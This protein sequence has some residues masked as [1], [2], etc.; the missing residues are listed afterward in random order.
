MDLSDYRPTATQ[1]GFLRSRER[2]AGFFSGYGGGKTRAGA[3]KALRLALANPGCTGLIAAPTWDMNT[4]LTQRAFFAACPK[5]LI[6]R[7]HKTE[8]WV[9]LV[10]GARIYFGSTDK[11]GSL[12]GTNLA[13]FW[14][15]EARLTSSEAWRVIVG[16]LRD[17]GARRLQGFVTTTPAM[18]W[19]NDEFGTGRPEREA[20]H[21]STLENAHN[22]A[23]GFIENLRRTYSPRLAKALI[24]GLFAVI[25]GQVYEEFDES[26]HVIDW[27]FNPRLPLWLSWDFGIRASSILFAQVTGDFPT[28]LASGRTIPPRSVVIFDELQLEQKPTVHQIPEVKRKL[29]ALR[30][31][32]ARIVCDPAGKQ[33]DQASG[34]PSVSLLRDAFGHIVRWEEEFAQRHIPNRI[35]RVQ[36]ALHPVEGEPT[37]YVARSLLSHPSGS[38]EARRG[39]VRSLRGSVYPEREGRR[40]S[41]L[42]KEDEFE[43]ARDTLEYLVVRAQNETRRPGRATGGTS[44][45]WGG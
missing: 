30:A 12:E 32:P 11:P 1:A 40:L 34:M 45:M 39:V 13:W 31:E 18:G 36:G 10:N 35:A 21:G 33:R 20:F 6:V 37:L 9:D 19:L 14:L 22:L 15:D 23:P 27:R 42:P 24:D 16:R 29:A 17:K 26:R 3:E 25:A 8:K 4:R 43:H 7:E 2:I 44:V 28:P 5:P 38:P 41:D